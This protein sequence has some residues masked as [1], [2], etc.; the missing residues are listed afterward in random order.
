[1]H[2]VIPEMEGMY[3][4][5]QDDFTAK[6]LSQQS[7]QKPAIKVERPS[8]NMGVEESNYANVATTSSSPSN[9]AASQIQIGA[10]TIPSAS[11]LPSADV[12][13]P[14][15]MLATTASS[16]QYAMIDLTKK[17]R[18]EENTEEEALPSPPPPLPPPLPS[19]VS[20]DEVIIK[21]QER[22]TPQEKSERSEDYHKL[23]HGARQK[24]LD[25]T[26]F[27]QSAGDFD[28]TYD[29]IT[30][31]SATLSS[32]FPLTPGP[33][34]Q[35]CTTSPS[36]KAFTLDTFITNHPSATKA[37]SPLPSYM[38]QLNS[39]AAAE[40]EYDTVPV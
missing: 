40:P 20:Y 21:G 33:H 31:Q 18:K 36:K 13:D 37:I 29:T 24:T 34:S 3:D 8:G 28:G 15:S 12:Y 17:R 4:T 30:Q 27:E 25:F 11:S 26:T 16:T 19:T 35:Q 6:P 7:Q 14:N 39:S 32:R 5:V 22:N 38:P 10:A 1:M 23:N 2:V 9:Q